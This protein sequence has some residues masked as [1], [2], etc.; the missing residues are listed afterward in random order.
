[1]A[2]AVV[3]TDGMEKLHNALVRGRQLYTQLSIFEGCLAELLHF[4]C[5]QLKKKRKSRRLALFL[6]LSSAQIEQ[7]SLNCRV[8]DVVKFKN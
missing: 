6:M 7:V 8:F 1:M 3:W 2:G 5:C 4:L